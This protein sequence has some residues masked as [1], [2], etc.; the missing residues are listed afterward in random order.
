MLHYP[1]GSGPATP[2]AIFEVYNWK[3][4]RRLQV[5]VRSTPPFL[6]LLS[7]PQMRSMRSPCYSTFTFIAPDIVALP[8]CADNTIELCRVG[9][10]QE[11]TNGP[12]DIQTCCV[13]SLPQLSKGRSVTQMTCRS[14]PK[15]TSSTRNAPGLRS[16]EPFHLNPENAIAIFNLM[17]H[18][19][20]GLHEC[21]TLIVHTAALL[22]ML[23]D[24]LPPS[25]P[26]TVPESLRPDGMDGGNALPLNSV[27]AS[28]NNSDTEVPRG[29]SRHIPWAEW[30]IR[31]CRWL[32]TSVGASRWITT[33][34]GQRYVTVEEDPMDDET[35]R[36][37]IVVYDFN[38]HTVRRLALQ[39][40]RKRHHLIR[41]WELELPEG[42][43]VAGSIVTDTVVW[44]HDDTALI[45]FTNS[46]TKV[47]GQIQCK[48]TE[49]MA[50]YP[51]DYRIFDVP[52]RTSLPYA[53]L[54]SFE[55]YAY[56]AVL[57]D[58]NM[59]IGVKVRNL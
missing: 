32:E 21:L 54:S 23:A 33:T 52:V 12:A 44:Y 50:E 58:R 5:R 1:S 11:D 48:P 18:D 29:S 3:S 39:H 31:G 45:P 47:I 2:P 22:A 20:Q 43:A 53:Q 27:P 24:P 7:M 15:M 14:E 41:H 9:G 17:T 34:C 10:V 6:H 16:S 30:G 56:G 19:G 59:V 25:S 35:T 51:E 40:R 49:L 26:S 37:T 13:L 36:S 28:G 57:L 8:N 38:P 42:E 4:A 55:T 46:R